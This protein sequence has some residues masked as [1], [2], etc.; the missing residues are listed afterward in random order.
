LPQGR[1]SVVTASTLALVFQSGN[2]Q[3]PFELIEGERLPATAPCLRVETRRAAGRRRTTQNRRAIQNPL[4]KATSVS[5]TEGDRPLPRSL[6]RRREAEHPPRCLSGRGSPA[7]HPRRISS[8][9]S[10]PSASSLPLG[11]SRGSRRV[12]YHLGVQWPATSMQRSTGSNPT[13]MNGKMHAMERRGGCE[14]YR[15]E[16][17]T[18]GMEPVSQWR[19]PR[20]RR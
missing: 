3:A 9:G 2:K 18:D 15:R 8:R 17:D 20:G 6:G 13:V 4:A 11:C 5:G 16:A 1:S 14:Y 7:C 12:A 19:S 10:R